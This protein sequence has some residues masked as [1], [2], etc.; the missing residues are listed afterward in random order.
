MEGEGLLARAF[1]HEIDHLSGNLYV[2]L[3]EDG[4]HDVKYEEEEE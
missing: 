3:V 1:C 4:L 2:D